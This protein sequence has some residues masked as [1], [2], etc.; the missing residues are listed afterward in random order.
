M[1][2]RA[3]LDG[4]GKY[5]LYRDSISGPS[6][7]QRVAIRAQQLGSS[8]PECQGSSVGIVTRIQARRQRNLERVPTDARNW[9]ISLFSGVSRTAPEPSRPPTQ[10]LL[11]PRCGGVEERSRHKA[12]HSPSRAEYQTV[13]STISIAGCLIKQTSNSYI[14]DKNVFRRYFPAFSFWWAAQPIKWS[15]Q[16]TWWWVSHTAYGGYPITLHNTSINT[17]EISREKSCGY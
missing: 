2:P 10:W 1:G 11:K 12:D 13:W 7:P 3:G 17:A 14:I 6:S 8:G 9:E 4:Y 16:T 5:R 15:S